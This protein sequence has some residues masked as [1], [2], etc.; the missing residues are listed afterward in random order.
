MPREQ[1]V[2]EP[3]PAEVEAMLRMQHQQQMAQQQAMILAECRAV[4]A[5]VFGQ[6]CGRL[7]KEGADDKQIQRLAIRSRDA[8]TIFLA[9]MGMNI[10]WDPK[11]PRIE[12]AKDK[13]PKD[14]YPQDKQ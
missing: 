11:L 5:Q 6:E 8:A 14:K 7:L 2:H 12:D 4:A 13:Q 10:N 3:S 1:T 9:A